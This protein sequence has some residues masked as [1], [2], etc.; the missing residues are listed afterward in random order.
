MRRG[1]SRWTGL[2]PPRGSRSWSRL[3]GALGAET[4]RHAP[5]LRVLGGGSPS[6]ERQRAAG[7]PRLRPPLH[8]VALRSRRRAAAA[9]PREGVVLVYGPGSSLV[10]MICS[11][12]PTSRSASASRP[13][14]AAPRETSASRR[15]RPARSSA[16]SSSTGRSSTGTSRRSPRPSTATSTSAT[17]AAPLALGRRASLD[18]A[19]S[20][21]TA[22]PHAPDVPSRPMGRSVASSPRSASTTDAPNLAWSYELITPESGILLGDDE[23]V[24]VGFELLMALEGAR[25]LGAERRR[26]LRRLVP[27]SIRLP[28]HARRRAP[29]AAVPSDL[30]YA[31]E[32]FGLEYTQDETYYVME[33]TPGAR[34][35]LGLRDDADLEQFRAAAERAEQGVALEADRYRPGPAGRAAPALPDPG[36]DAA[37]ERRGQRRPRD[38]RDAVPLHA[39]LLRLAAARPRRP[40]PAGARAPR[41]RQPRPGRRR[42]RR[43][44]RADARAAR[45]PPRERVGG[46]RAR[47]ASRIS[48]SPSTGST[49][50]MRSTTTRTDGSTSSTSLQARRW[51]SR[52]SAATSTRSRTPRRSSC[53]PPSGAYRIRV[54]RGGRIARS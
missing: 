14:D 45:R 28:R 4:H 34:V 27:D 3:R 7:G 54:A 25:V 36:R 23:P 22:V 9:F 29:V 41:L 17:R 18:V 38:Q 2:P 44:R 40:A 6:H 11:G 10:P 16:C 39:S 24:E 35:F 47:P 30:A 52:R 48:S 8:P 12:T 5:P 46:A 43:G 19:R 51:R 15:A 21:R 31:R 33:T 13:C 37:R 50:P 26:A 49:S 42:G 1:S 53:P 20:R 32:T